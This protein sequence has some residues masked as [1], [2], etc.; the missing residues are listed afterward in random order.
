[1]PEVPSCDVTAGGCR[2]VLSCHIVLFC[3]MH[4]CPLNTL[5]MADASQN[6]EPSQVAGQL[7]VPKVGMAAHISWPSP[8][9]VCGARWQGGTR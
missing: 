7:K 9:H 6:S 3:S 2:P 8:W 4:F 1:M 5:V